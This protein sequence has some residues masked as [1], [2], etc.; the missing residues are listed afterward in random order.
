MA[1]HRDAHLRD[2]ATKQFDS[3]VESGR[4]LGCT[5]LKEV[6]ATDEKK[7]CRLDGGVDD[8]GTPRLPNVEVEGGQQTL[9]VWMGQPPPRKT[10]RNINNSR[11]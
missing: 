1:R 10:F 2:A 3:A 5:D 8:D 9:R 4:P 6:F 11:R 7:R